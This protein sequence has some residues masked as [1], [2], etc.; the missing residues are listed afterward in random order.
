VED[1]L[2]AIRQL[3]EIQMDRADLD[4]ALETVNQADPLLD[5]VSLI[6]RGRVSMLRGAILRRMGRLNEAG[7]AY[8]QALALYRKAGAA[9][10]A[11]ST[12]NSIALVAREER[13]LADA[14]AAFRESLRARESVDPR[15]NPDA[16]TTLANLG[17]LLA[18]QERLEEAA[19]VLARSI[20]MHRDL[21][22]DEHFS[23]AIPLVSLAQVQS[24]LGRHDEAIGAIEQGLGLVIAQFGEAHPYVVTTLS[25][26][27]DA[28]RRGAR[29]KEARATYER[30]IRMSGTLGLPPSVFDLPIRCG[31]IETLLLLDLR[32][33]AV[34]CY[35]QGVE[36]L[37]DDETGIAELR[38]RMLELGVL[39]P[40]D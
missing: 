28:E 29:L 8:E 9:I 20:A 2:H 13:R 1:E 7:N 30:A 26:K 33:Q 19:T 32:S 40:P 16:A 37:G 34:A 39:Q 25:E 27:A 4:A 36:I 17:R 11:S 31:L 35:E 24:K 23:L 18:S 10:E 21:Y 6:D 22:G 12:L 15:A 38:S 14:E 5:R 3:G